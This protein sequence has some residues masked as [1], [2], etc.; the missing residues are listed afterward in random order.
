MSKRHDLKVSLFD[1][2]DSCKYCL[3]HIEGMT[4]HQFESDIKTIH[5]VQHQLLV[6]VMTLL[7]LCNVSFAK[8]DSTKEPPYKKYNYF[9]EEDLRTLRLAEMFPKPIA[10]YFNLKFSCTHWNNEGGY[11]DKINGECKH[12]KKTK[13]E[14][15]KKHQKENNV[16]ILFKKIDLEDDCIDSEC[17][18]VKDDPD[19]KSKA[20]DTYYEAEAQRVISYYQKDIN[21]QDSQKSLKKTFSIHGDSVSLVSKNVDRLHPRTLKEFKDM[22]DD[23]KKRSIS[24]Q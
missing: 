3:R 24:L 10:D 17:S 2:L 1:M 13:E 4:F 9:S 7:L 18:F 5:A 22:V 6:L 8:A 20:L 15:L 19:H 12:L 14:I 21:T 23:L 11:E 16:I